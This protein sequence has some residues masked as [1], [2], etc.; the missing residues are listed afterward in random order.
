MLPIFRTYV[1]FQQQPATCCAS[2]AVVLGV[3]S[4]TVNSVT[5]VADFPDLCINLAKSVMIHSGGPA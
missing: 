1:S 2:V 4:F 3:K 5:D